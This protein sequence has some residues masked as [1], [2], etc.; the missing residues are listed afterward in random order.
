MDTCDRIIIS[1]R[2]YNAILSETSDKISTETGGI[3]LGR[4]IGRIWFII[5][6][7]DPGPNSVFEISHFEYD[8]EYVNYLA[9]VLSKQYKEGLAVLGL[10]HRHPGSLDTFSHADD[11][12][13]SEF[14]RLS[15]IGAISALVNIDPV[16]RLTIY[17]VTLPLKY[18]KLS[19][20]VNDSLI[21]ENLLEYKYFSAKKSSFRFVEV[22][23]IKPKKSK[24][25]TSI[26]GIFGTKKIIEAL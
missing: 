4:V 16:L 14:V 17:H 19:F 18:N 22:D 5:E 25:F 12:T 10:W 13:N 3:L 2:A 21:S 6:S 11:I 7:I 15:G 1:S 24:L 9:K 26:K 20:E 23:P 8:T